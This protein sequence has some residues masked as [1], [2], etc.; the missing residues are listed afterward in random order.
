MNFEDLSF[1]HSCIQRVIHVRKPFSS[2]GA[3]PMGVLEIPFGGKGLKSILST[4]KLETEL[5]AVPLEY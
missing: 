3:S 1:L 2:R 4:T 5:K